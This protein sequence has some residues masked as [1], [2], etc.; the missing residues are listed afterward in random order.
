[1]ASTLYWL[2]SWAGLGEPPDRQVLY[3]GS[4][5]RPQG[6]LSHNQLRLATGDISRMYQANQRRYMRRLHVLLGHSLVP[7]VTITAFQQP[8]VPCFPARGCQSLLLQGFMKLI[9]SI[10]LQNKRSCI[11]HTRALLLKSRKRFIVRLLDSF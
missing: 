6:T 10:D 2:R 3:K 7:V 8:N 11:W 9:L 1:M 4:Q 5:L